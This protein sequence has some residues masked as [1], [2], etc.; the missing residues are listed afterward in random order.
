MINRIYYLNQIISKMWDG[1]IKAITGIKRC[2]KSILLFELFYDY[3]IIEKAI[4]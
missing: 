4:N 2:G 1:N 3:L